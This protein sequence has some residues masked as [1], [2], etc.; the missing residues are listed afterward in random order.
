[1]ENIERKAMEVPKE[2]VVR[3]KG[4]EIKPVDYQGLKLLESAKYDGGTSIKYWM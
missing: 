4:V 3:E 1:M 2:V